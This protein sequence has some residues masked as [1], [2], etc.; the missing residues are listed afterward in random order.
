MSPTKVQSRSITS[1]WT[2]G[3][4]MATNMSNIRLP[5]ARAHKTQAL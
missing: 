1:L 4:T 2:A 5:H 3:E